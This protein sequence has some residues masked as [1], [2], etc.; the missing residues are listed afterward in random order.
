L[1]AIDRFNVILSSLQ[2]LIEFHQHDSGFN[3]PNSDFELAMDVIR[4]LRL[5][6]HVALTYAGEEHRQ[7]EQFSKWLRH[8]IDVQVTD[9]NSASAQETRERDVGLDYGL[10]LTYIEGPLENS[11]LTAFIPSTP[12]FRDLAGNGPR[13]NVVKK[14]LDAFRDDKEID[15]NLLILDSHFQELQSHCNSLVGRITNWLRSG[16]SMNY[17]ITLETCT[18]ATWDVR[19]VDEDL[20]STY[21]AVVPRDQPSEGRLMIIE[22]QN[23]EC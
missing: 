18:A 10:L 2:G 12:E 7:F 14:A 4:C 15:A 5:L 1:P 19:M 23:L 21:V 17:R 22:C 16:S 11:K 20:V 8:E 13:Y 3:I 9:P 6:A